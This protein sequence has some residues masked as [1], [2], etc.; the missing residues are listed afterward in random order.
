[1]AEPKELGESMTKIV[2]L[3][4][5]SVPAKLFATPPL[6]EVLNKLM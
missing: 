4:M 1:M 6:V 3:A 5:V 2:S